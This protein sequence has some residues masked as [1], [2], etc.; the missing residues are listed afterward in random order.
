MVV[1]P[2]KAGVVRICVDL[3]PLNENVLH[4]VHPF[5]KVDETLA[6]L[7]GATVFSKLDANSGFWQIP[8]ATESRLLTTFTT[9]F[10]QFC[11]N[12]PPFGISS[13]PELFQKWMSGILLG[14]DGVVC[15]INELVLSA[16]CELH[17]PS[18]ELQ[19]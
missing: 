14:L 5:A 2:K 18:R 7:A 6:R 11:F 9:P 17:A 3:I 8:L 10:G 13:A 12:K 15:Q 4:E 19:P 16:S 1:V